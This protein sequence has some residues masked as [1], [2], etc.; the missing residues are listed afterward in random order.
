MVPSDGVILPVY[1]MAFC[2]ASH[3]IASCSHATTH[4]IASCSHAATHWAWWRVSACTPGWRPRLMNAT[5]WNSCA[6]FWALSSGG[7]NRHQ[8]AR[9][10]KSKSVI[11]MD[12]KNIHIADSLFETAFNTLR[13]PHSAEYKAGVLAALRDR[14]NQANSSKERHDPPYTMGTAECDAWVAGYQEGLLIWESQ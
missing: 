13:E 10:L 8:F 7:L 6:A 5:S 12:V 3:I 4:K 9:H 11:T 14:E 2:K 1:E